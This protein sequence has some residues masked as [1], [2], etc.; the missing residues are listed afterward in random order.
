[1][2]THDDLCQLPGANLFPSF[3]LYLSLTEHAEALAALVQ[4]LRLQ[5]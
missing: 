2:S 5:S 1:M 4:D 3:P